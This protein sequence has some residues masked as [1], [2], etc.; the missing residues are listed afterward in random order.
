LKKYK[1][2]V[3]NNEKCNL[4]IHNFFENKKTMEESKLFKALNLMPKG[5]IHHIH[6]TSANTIDSY[7]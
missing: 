6:S 2:E 3:A 5:G 1:E 7:L 4:T